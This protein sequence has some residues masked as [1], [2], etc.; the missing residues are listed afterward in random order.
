MGEGVR[1][2][3]RVVMIRM[4][5]FVKDLASELPA[6]LGSLSVPCENARG[7]TRRY[8]DAAACAQSR[9]HTAANGER[10]SRCSRERANARE[11]NMRG[12]GGLKMSGGLIETCRHGLRTRTC[13]S[14]RMCVCVYVS[15]RSACRLQ[16]QDASRR[17]RSWRM[18][19]GCTRRSRGFALEKEEGEEHEEGVEQGEEG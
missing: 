19:H 12:G 4:K 1:D 15:I 9:M 10:S 14:E 17:H 6:S 11:C 7:V 8:R 16:R 13:T 3:T 5:F 18:M 2:T